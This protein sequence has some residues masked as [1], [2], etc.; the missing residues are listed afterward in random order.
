MQMHRII[1]F[2][3]VTLFCS[4][5]L[6]LQQPPVYRG[7]VDLVRLGVTVTDRQGRLITNL[8]ADD[9]DVQEDGVRQTV[10]YFVNATSPAPGM[11]LGLLL[12][13]S[14]SMEDDIAF[15]RTASIR[16]VRAL[17]EAVDI[18]LADFDTEV[19]LVQYTQ[20]DIPRLVERIR[21]RKTHGDTALFD[22]IGVYLD[23]AADQTGRKVMLLYTDGGDTRSAMG[24]SGVMDLLKASDVTVYA[25]GVF[26]QR[27]MTGRVDQ[28]L[29]LR[30]IAD[31]T[32]GKAFFPLSIKDLDKAYEE[33]LA[34]I[35]A[36]YTL[37]YLSTNVRLN[38]AWRKVDIKIRGGRAPD[39]RLRARKGY[40]ALYRP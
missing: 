2:G 35:R 5:I 10:Q 17:D 25:I 27:S 31:A 13:V 39:A 32:G 6:A 20:A 40:F 22:A 3:A 12:D 28:Q 33:V 16:F 23:G 29:V 7:G 24:L 4:Q 19:R 38:G 8:T 36:Q 26:D 9:F 14:D 11:H 21:M 30:Q 37:G 34:E 18:T 15:T 1:T